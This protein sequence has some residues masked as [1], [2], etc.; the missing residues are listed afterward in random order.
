MY[1][2]DTGVIA[3]IQKG[4]RCDRRVSA[5]YETVDA[6]DLYISVLV[7]GEIR[8]GIER[9]RRRDRDAAESYED[10]IE[11]IRRGFSDRILVV[12]DPVVQEWGRIAARVSLPV[13]E[14]LLAATASVHGL[15]LVTRN[16]RDVEKGGVRCLNPFG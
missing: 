4:D 13:V 15:A 3:E 8:A 6:D 2:L 1:L 10:W 5:W 9:M 12:D 7:I 14:G 11:M 16:I